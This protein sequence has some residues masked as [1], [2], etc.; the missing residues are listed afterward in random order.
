[1]PCPD[2]E[3]RLALRGLREDYHK[4]AEDFADWKK[5]NSEEK[6]GLYQRI[7]HLENKAMFIPSKEESALIAEATAF[8][9]TKREFRQKLFT[10]LIEK[11]LWG[12]VIFI[13]ASVFFY[14]KQL[15]IGDV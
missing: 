12:V 13:A 11:G 8:Y 14:F 7:S 2:D 4:L 15:I 3:I 5:A 10:S 9:K 6:K 1:M